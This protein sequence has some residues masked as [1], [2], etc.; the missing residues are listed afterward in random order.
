M[1]VEPNAFANHFDRSQIHNLIQANTLNMAAPRPDR[2]QEGPP[3]PRHWVDRDDD[4]GLIGSHLTAENGVPVVVTGPAGV[5][6]SSLAAMLAALLSERF[7]DGQLYVDLGADDPLTAMRS[8]LFRLGVPTPYISESLGGMVSQYRTA[9]RDKALLVIVDEAPSREAGT[10]FAPASPTAG[11]LL[12]GHVWP[13]DVDVVRHEMRDLAAPHSAALLAGICPEL[14]EAEAA[15][16]VAELA[17]SPAKVRAL[18]GF[19]RALG[20]AEAALPSGRRAVTEYSTD[21][22]ITATGQM[23]SPSAAWLHRLLS[24]LP[25]DDFDAALLPAVDAAEAFGE[26]VDAQL[27]SPVSPGRY[28]LEG[29]TSATGLPIELAHAMRAVVSWYRARAQRAD[30]EVMGG[31]LRLA[32]VDGRPEFATLR[33]DAA[34]PFGEHE[35]LPWLRAN[36]KTLAGLVRLAAVAG[37]GDESWALAEALW[38]LYTNTP[39]PEEAVDCYRAAAEAAT[40]PIPKARMLICL[41]RRLI[42]VQGHTEAE[43]ALEAALAA[44]REAGGDLGDT[45]VCSALEQLGWLHYRRERWD[46]AEDAYRSSLRLAERLGRN[47]SQALLHKLIGFVHRDTERFEEAR[48]DFAASL[49]RFEREDDQRNLAVVRF[50]LAALAIRAGDLNAA[51]AAEAA[52][53]TMRRRG[54]DRAAA[55]A[56]ERLGLL[57]DG[58]DGRRWLEAALEMFDRFGGPDADRVRG[59]LV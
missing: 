23:L 57:L 1:P 20:R 29:R 12:T 49:P 46:A 9:T 27:A 40:E 21:E 7:P 16:Y 6:K 59:L 37:W 18:A 10:L 43:A 34:R 13:E 24:H 25:G 26:L 32:G 28:R 51:T 5:G 4:L 44:A 30:W 58:A 56:M 54:L 41:G 11:F 19:I 38:A 35:G 33:P 22:L 55:E 17:W 39:L 8:V 31:R 52:I 48:R 2:P 50:E 47:R 45:L 14:T 3:L 36:H 15:Q 42:D 53:A